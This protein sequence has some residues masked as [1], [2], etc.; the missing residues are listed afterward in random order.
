MRYV[1]FK[2]MDGLEAVAFESA[3]IACEYPTLGRQLPFR[4]W[5]SECPFFRTKRLNA[6]SLQPAQ[7]LPI[8]AQHMWVGC[9]AKTADFRH[10]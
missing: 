5:L 1:D 8:S 2:L 3:Q 9:P 6:A 7:N 4:V 10:S